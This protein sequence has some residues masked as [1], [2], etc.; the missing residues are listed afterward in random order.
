[1][2]RGSI[3]LAVFIFIL[4]LINTDAID[5]I[6]DCAE[7]TIHTNSESSWEDKFNTSAPEEIVYMSLKWN[8]C[9]NVSSPAYTTF[10]GLADTDGDG[11]DELIVV[12][13]DG[14]LFAIEL[15]SGEISGYIKICLLYTSPSPRDRG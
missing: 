5:P 14:S 4:P 13:S 9:L 3:I 8:T 7:L 2:R 10:R 11:V 6:G 15:G 1:M 12:I